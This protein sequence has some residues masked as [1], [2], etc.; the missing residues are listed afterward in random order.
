[1]SVTAEVSVR[2]DE[3][4]TALGVKLLPHQQQCVS[5]MIHRENQT[6][7]GGILADD[8]GLGKT[9]STI[10]LIVH[11]RK[12]RSP[13]ILEQ[14][15]RIAELAAKVYSEATLV[16][17]PLSLVNQWA[18]EVEDKLIG[19]ALSVYVFHGPRREVNAERY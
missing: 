15:R 14:R 9:V 4:P 18:K 13:V 19:T 6:P 7:S 12:S 3:H 5:W 11:Q 1:M 10:S 8:M 16:V 17:A 2:T